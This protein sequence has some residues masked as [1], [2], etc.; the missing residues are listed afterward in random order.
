[1]LCRRCKDLFW[2]LKATKKGNQKEILYHHDA[3]RFRTGSCQDCSVCKFFRSSSRYQGKISK[4]AWI[5]ETSA[6]YILEVDVHDPKNPGKESN[7]V[8]YQ[9][10][11]V[12]SHNGIDTTNQ[13]C[14]NSLTLLQT[15]L[16]LVS[17]NRPHLQG[18]LLVWL[19]PATGFRTVR[20]TMK[21]ADNIN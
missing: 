12:D 19:L 13:Q 20:E 4:I 17:M 10:A 18:P 16:A 3:R 7:K 2:K 15:D 14:L 9:A 8:L 21:S 1:M 11:R 5:K 6:N